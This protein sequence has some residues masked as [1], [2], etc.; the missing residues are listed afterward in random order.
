MSKKIETIDINATAHDAAMK[1]KDKNVSSLLVVDQ[2]SEQVNQ[3]ILTERD[4]VRRVCATD[5]PDLNVPV[6]TIM[7]SPIAFIDPF[8]P[9]EVA[10]DNMRHYGMRHFLVADESGKALGIITLSDLAGYLAENVNID[11]VN[12]T[13]LKALKDEGGYPS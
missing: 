9:V 11:D 2:Q 5:E 13:I 4:L 10:A 3:G 7:S 1:M 6:K 8:S 12:A